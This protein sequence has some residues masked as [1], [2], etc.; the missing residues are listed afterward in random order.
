MFGYTV[1][2]LHVENLQVYKKSLVDGAAT[3]IQE[4]CLFSTK[5]INF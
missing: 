2:D 4:E 5:A 1:S 3:G